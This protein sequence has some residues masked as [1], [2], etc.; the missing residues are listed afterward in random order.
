MSICLD[1]TLSNKRNERN[2]QMR[3]ELLVIDPQIDFCW[4]GLNPIEVSD[5]GRLVLPE[6]AFKPG[7]LYVPGAEKDMERV[8]AMV[9]RLKDKL[10]DIH[11]TLD[12]HHFI[13]IA[14]PI[15]LMNSKGEHP[16]PFTVVSDDDIKN[17]VWRATNP[18]FQKRL[19][20]YSSSLKDNGRYPLCVWPP[21]CLIGSW[22]Y[23][24]F[25][26]LY[27]ALL[28]WEKDFAM[29]DYVTKGSNFW[30]EHYS[31]VQADVPDPED[32]DTQL[33]MRLIE[34][35]QEADEILLAGEARSHCLANTVLDIANNFGEENIKKMVLLEDATSDVPGFEELGENFVKEMK[36]RGMRVSST[37]EYLK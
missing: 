31:A 12:S 13:D 17:G 29:V 2:F 5:A 21:H 36:G 9:L 32:P 19:E 14:H 11:V 33:N 15:F 34:T 16:G 37:E 6:E 24:V 1:L 35:L 30:T 3:I 25:P 20:D 22:G 18:S 4:P 27:K 10:D 26:P 8:A 7:A 28:E 23:G